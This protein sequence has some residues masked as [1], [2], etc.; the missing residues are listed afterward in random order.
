MDNI[1]ATPRSDILGRIADLLKQGK[2]YANQY[3]VLPQVPML[4]GTGLG[5]LFMGRAPELMD[6][7]SYDG[8]RGA[9]RGGNLAT[10]GI[11][12]YGAR[13]EVA[14]AALLGMDVA[15]LGGLAKLGGKAAMRKMDKSV[16]DAVYQAITRQF[17]LNKMEPKHAAAPWPKDTS[18]QA[19]LPPRELW[20]TVPREMPKAKPTIEKAQ[21]HINMSR[22]DFL[23]KSGAIAGSAALG[24]GLLR[25]FSDNVVED[26]VPKVLDNT[27]T[28]SIKKYKFNT[29]QDYIDNLKGLAADEGEIAYHENGA[30]DMGWDAWDD[31]WYH[32]DNPNGYDNFIKRR[33]LGDEQ[34][35]SSMKA[36]QA[37]GFSPQ[38][39]EETLNM[40]SPQAKQE[41][42]AFKDINKRV[43]DSIYGK[44]DPRLSDDWART[45]TTVE[46][47][48]KYIK[49]MEE[50]FTLGYF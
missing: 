8:I 47:P 10:G 48:V 49:G 50:G 11:G 4:G 20:N 29:L 36:G 18:A 44:D 6:N 13:P 45:L 2:E 16:E 3:Q 32:P 12:T 23:K 40:F 19:L 42:K 7:I 21:E 39:I 43:N 28:A 25:K 37:D 26:V 46:D 15:G 35:Y 9:T 27:A 24:G 30:F 17:D 33:L 41:M 1:Q 22:R 34:L 31:A 14:D 38:E 5:D